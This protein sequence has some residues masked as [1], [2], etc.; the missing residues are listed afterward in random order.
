MRRTA[1][2]L[3]DGR[4]FL[5]LLQHFLKTAFRNHSKMEVRGFTQIKIPHHSHDP[6][7]TQ[8]GERNN[9]NRRYAPRRG[10]AYRL[11]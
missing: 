10:V 8:P 1:P 11:F 5:F 7:W 6:S 2:S 9:K 3:Q 4:G